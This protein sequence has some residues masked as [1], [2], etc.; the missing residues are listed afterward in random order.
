MVIGAASASNSS[1]R[2][3]TNPGFYPPLQAV[4]HFDDKNNVT[5]QDEYT[6]YPPH[7][8]SKVYVDG[9]VTYFDSIHKAS[10]WYLY[11]LSFFFIFVAHCFLALV[12]FRN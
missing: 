6:F 1:P 8:T 3:V 9:K 11:L 2:E 4:R 10:G 5:S 7:G 12:Y